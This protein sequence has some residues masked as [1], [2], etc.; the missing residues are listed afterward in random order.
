[1]NTTKGMVCTIVLEWKHEV[2]AT[3][4]QSTVVPPRGGVLEVTRMVVTGMFEE[5]YLKVILIT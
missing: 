2:W 1:M 5:Q 4:D 3:G